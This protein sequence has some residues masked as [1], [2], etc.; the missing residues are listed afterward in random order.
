MAKQRT[1]FA[2]RAWHM[3]APGVPGDLPNGR[4]STIVRRSGLKGSDDFLA[5]SIVE[6][7]MN[8]IPFTI[9]GCYHIINIGVDFK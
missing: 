3:L 2:E 7:F 1:K 9:I 8:F 4:S 6:C 5:C